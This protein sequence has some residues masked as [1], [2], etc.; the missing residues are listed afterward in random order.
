MLIQQLRDGSDGILAKVIIGLI[1]IVFGLFGFGSITTF[2][3]P[4]AKVATVNGEDVTQQ[5][6]EVA[7]ERNRRLLLARGA[8]P[9]DIDEDLLRESVLQSLISRELLSQAADRLDLYF[10]DADLDAE[11]VASEVFQ[12]DGVFN[13]DQFQ[14]VIRSARYTPLS[15]RDE[16]RTDNLFEQMLSGIRQTAFVTGS[17]SQRY[18]SLFSQTRDIAF[19]TIPVTSLIEEVTVTD[20]DIAD[21]YNGNPSQFVTDETVSL[22]YVEIRHDELAA[23]LEL[24]TTLVEQY[25]E[26]N[27][28]A[29]STEE[30]RRLAHILIE[31]TDDVAREDALARADAVYEQILNGED[32]S[33]LAESASDDVGSAGNAGDLGFNA[34][35]TFFPQFEAVAY[36]LAVNEVSRPVE[37]DIGFH[38]IKVLEIEEGKVPSL[39]EI[40][41]EVEA[42]YRL[43]ATEDDFV[44]MSNRL[45]ELLFESIDLEVPVNELRLEKFS[46]GQLSRDATHP[47][48]S[49]DRVQAAAFSADVLLDG[50]NSDLI[51][52]SDSYHI[53]LRVLEHSPAEVRPLDEVAEDIRYI[54]QRERSR[55][56][57]EAQ[58]QDIVE[59]IEGGSLAQ[60]VAD[61]FGLNWEL[62]ENAPR[63]AQNINPVVIQEA[64]KL[65]RPAKDRES[66]GWASL[67]NGDTVVLRV[68]EVRNRPTV[69]LASTELAGIRSGYAGQLGAVDFQEFEDSLAQVADIDRSN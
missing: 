68:S 46:T 4:V 3:A 66:L 30:N 25:Y 38:I 56:L 53:G 63:F 54:L 67:P 60:F 19:L 23:D 34:P 17:E 8:T 15:Y 51:E 41:T 13:P 47:L 22:E 26:E 39:D 18:S 40:R 2:L 49:D 57:A 14:N 31:I 20:E 44:S 62:R 50:N 16:M 21:Y 58:A 29:Y 24:D 12:I 37:T 10:S 42:A 7:V 59:Q 35:G 45:A 6:M 27:L 9:Q 55:Q 43:S 52:I 32:F 36:D 5:S 33:V 69:D 64:F 28:A 1:I 48:M 11:I 61:Q 65:P